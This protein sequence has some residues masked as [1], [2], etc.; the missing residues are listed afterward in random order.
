M[1]QKSSS[2][3]TNTEKGTT[4]VKGNTDSNQPSVQAQDAPKKPFPSSSPQA[5][6]TAP[7]GAE[8]ELNR[9][10]ELIVGP[11]ILQQR[12]RGAEADRIR[13]IIFGGQMQEYERRFTDLQREMERVLTD[14]RQVQDGISDFEKG[15]TKRI[16]TLERETRQTD[17]ELRREVDRL[18]AQEAMMQ[19]LLT[20]VRQQEILAQTSQEN[21]SEL[22]K[23]VGQQEQ[24]IRALRTTVNENRDQ[25]ERK[26]DIVK[27]E[28]RQAEDGLLTELRRVT[29]RLDNQ[30]TDRKALAGM[31]ME[32]ATRLETGSSVTGLLEGLSNSSQE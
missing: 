25:R 22:R 11:D 30:K 21:T 2:A 17:D 31:L 18:G 16:E 27:R 1:D 28:V 20:Q 29:D 23:A 6:Q 19:Q 12:L 3:E 15:Q 9:V 4:S 26:L 10:R 32:I 13:E 8:D 5:S 7:Q 24:S 14:L